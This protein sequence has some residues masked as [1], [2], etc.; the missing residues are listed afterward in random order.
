MANRYELVEGT[1]SKFWEIEL[2]GDSFTARWGRIGTAGQEKTQ[3]FDSAAEAKQA[4]DKLV[5]EKTKK[6]YKL[7]SSSGAKTEAPTRPVVKLEY[8]PELDT[9][10]AENRDDKATWQVYADWLLEQGQ[11]WGEVIV[12]AGAGKRIKKREDEIAAEWLDGLDGVEIKWKGGV[13]DELVMKPEEAPEEKSDEEK[14]TGALRR[15][16][17]HPAGRLVRSLTLGLPPRVPG[18]IDWHFDDVMEAIAESG[19]LPLL[20]SVDLTPDAEHMDQQ[21]WRRVGDISGLWKAA[22]RLRELRLQ[23][24][25]GSD[26]G[27]PIELGKIEAPHLETLVYISSGLSAEAPVALGKAKLPSLKHLELYFGREDYGNSCEI[28]SLDGILD[29]RG[30]PKLET[31][32]LKNSEWEAKLIDAVAQSPIVKRIQTLDLSLGILCTEGA[33]ALIKNASRLGHLKEINLDD[34]FL[35][36]DQ[37]KA[38]KKV[39]PNV[40]IGA[41]REPDGDLDDP[42]SRYTSVGE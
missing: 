8:K 32:G 30:L 34:N 26:G 14:Y 5:A 19:P 39:L 17:A 22:P 18:D 33:E 3:S 15:I 29:G 40:A 16:L 31:L 9:M 6:G 23:G 35:Q 13:V 42:Y 24:S 7:V 12:A 36:P 4:H 27:K 25:S 2:S 10:L 28:D 37:V 21:S 41:Q 11:S 1:S 20:E 38:I